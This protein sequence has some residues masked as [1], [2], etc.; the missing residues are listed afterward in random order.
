MAILQN[1]IV[2]LILGSLVAAGAAWYLFLRDTAPVALLTTEDLTSSNAADKDVVE[3]LLALRAITLSGTIFTDPAFV[4][5]KDNG[6]QIIPEP[7]GRPNPFLPLE[8]SATAT[9][10]AS[11]STPRQPAGR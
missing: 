11:T 5:L 10:S 6:T 4:S 3:T 2:I 7:V 9:S 1:K 8:G